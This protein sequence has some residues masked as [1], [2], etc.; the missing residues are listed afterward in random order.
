MHSI[1]Q[2][3]FG[4]LSFG[5]RLDQWP[6]LELKKLQRACATHAF[7]LGHPLLILLGSGRILPAVEHE[8]RDLQVGARKAFMIPADQ[9]YGPVDPSLKLKIPRSKFP[10]GTE[11]KVGFQFQDGEDNDWPII[12]RVTKIDGDD[13]YA[14]GNHELAGV[15]LH[16]DVEITEKR[17][18]SADEISHGHAHRRSGVCG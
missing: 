5:G 6:I 18:A 4:H 7:S 2:L 12:Y 8:I 11:L 15:A 3:R 16:Y 9:A 14:D 10:E 1:K 17:D 13:I